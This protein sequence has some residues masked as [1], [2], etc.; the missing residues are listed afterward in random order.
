[1]NK[2]LLVGGAAAVATMTGCSSNV[3]TDSASGSASAA[4]S[5]APDGMPSGGPGGG[6]GGMGPG[7]SAVAYK[8]FVGVTAD[9]KIVEDLYSIHSTDVSTDA[10]VKAAQ[11]FLD[12]LTAK[13]R[14]A[15]QYDIQDDEWLAW[16]NVDGYERKGARM[17]DLTTKQRD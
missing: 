13:E 16:S 17:G 4:A 10:L 1:M 15:S 9:G 2:T 5:G 8:D 6:G 3:A 7:A 11:K 14:K 12:G